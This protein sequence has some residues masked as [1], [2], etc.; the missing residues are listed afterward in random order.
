MEAESSLAKPER[1]CPDCG[2]TETELY[3]KGLM[4]CPLCYKV[5]VREVRMAVEKLHGVAPPEAKNP[6]PTRRAE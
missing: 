4:G 2:M 3:T 1:V 5:F 6:W